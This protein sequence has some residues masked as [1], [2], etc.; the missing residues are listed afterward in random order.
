MAHKGFVMSQVAGSL[1][2]ASGHSDAKK[3]VNPAPA[4]SAEDTAVNAVEQVLDGLS[5]EQVDA[6]AERGA[7]AAATEIVASRH[8]FTIDQLEK[9]G[10]AAVRSA[11]RKS[12]RDFYRTHCAKRVSGR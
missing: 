8:E 9:L 7:R 5:V 2:G 10:A 1:P 11:A 12:V 6:V 4:P 3:I